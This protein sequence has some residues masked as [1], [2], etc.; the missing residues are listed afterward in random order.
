MAS[1]QQHYIMQLI[2]HTAIH[3]KYIPVVPTSI[4]F[5]GSLSIFSDG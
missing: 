4:K 3:I 2:I 1:L 5:I